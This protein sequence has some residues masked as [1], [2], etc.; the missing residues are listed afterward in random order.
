[1]LVGFDAAPQFGAGSGGGH[2]HGVWSPTHEPGNFGRLEGVLIAQAH[3]FLEVGSQS[4]HT[5]AK[6][7]RAVIWG[8]GAVTCGKEFQGLLGEGWT[9]G[10]AEGSEALEPCNR[11]GPREEVGGEI[12][13]SG[14]TGDGEEGFLRDILS[15]AEISDNRQDVGTQRRLMFEEQPLD[16]SEVGVWGGHFKGVMTGL[17]PILSS[18]D[19]NKRESGRFRAGM[20]GV[21]RTVSRLREMDASSN[22]VIALRQIFFGK[23]RRDLW[24]YR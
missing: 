19:Q 1:M 11:A 4:L 12:K 23:S 17:L 20:T 24:L 7:V 21:G 14:L 6:P 22:R 8:R 9:T 3:H 18:T 15:E 5:S 16:L 13:V 10:A 2:A